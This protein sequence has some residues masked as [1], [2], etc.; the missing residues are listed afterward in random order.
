MMNERVARLTADL[1]ALDR[2]IV[3]RNPALNPGLID[4]VNGWQGRYGKRGALRASIVK[5]LAQ[6]APQWLSSKEIGALVV[7]EL[8]ITFDL[9]SEGV[10]WHTNS[11]KSALNALLAKGAVERE[12]GWSPGSTETGRWRVKPVKVPTLADLQ[13]DLA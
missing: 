13:R 5:V 6:C 4:P 9:P 12:A 8:A 2:A 7:E 11:L 3:I 1:V 10:Q